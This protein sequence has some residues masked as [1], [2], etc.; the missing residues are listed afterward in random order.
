MAL[1]A[2]VPEPNSEATIENLSS[3]V[4]D[5]RA[6]VSNGCKCNAGTKGGV[7]CGWCGAVTNSGNGGSWSDAFQCNGSKCCRY[8]PRDSCR[9]STHYSPCG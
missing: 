8:G 2:A 9:D 5:K 7:Y 1:A 3:N 6:C 4:F